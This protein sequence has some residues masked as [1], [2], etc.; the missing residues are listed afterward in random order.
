MK[1]I[2]FAELT[3]YDFRFMIYDRGSQ[4]INHANQ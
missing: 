4:I 3:I 1:M 2:N